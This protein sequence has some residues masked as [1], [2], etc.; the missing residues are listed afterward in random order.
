MGQMPYRIRAA[1]LLAAAFLL[2][3]PAIAQTSMPKDEVGLGKGEY[4]TNCA[5][6]HGSEG[7]GDGPL[8]QFLTVPPANLTELAKTNNGQFPFSEVY[9]TIAGDPDIRAHGGAAM[10]VWGDYF[11]AQ[12]FVGGALDAEA[13]EYIARGRILSVVYYLQ[14]IQS[15]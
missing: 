13:A 5:V 4:E 10:P 14:A 7:Q 15:R 9:Q 2:A 3:A 6:C 8:A 12:A 11:E 1:T